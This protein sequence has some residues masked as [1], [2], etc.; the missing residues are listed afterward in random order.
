MLIKK[1]E[2]L[3]Q[4]DLIHINRHLYSAMKKLLNCFLVADILVHRWD[5]SRHRTTR[6]QMLLQHNY[7]YIWLN[8]EWNLHKKTIS[9]NVKHT[10]NLTFWIKSMR[11]QMGKTTLLNSIAALLAERI[12]NNGLKLCPWWNSAETH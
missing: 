9:V 1:Q 5:F 2:Q 7:Q 11:F 4:L 3:L 10:K 8:S 6:H 12:S